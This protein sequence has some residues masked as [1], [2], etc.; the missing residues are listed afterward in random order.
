MKIAIISSTFL[1]AHEGVSITLWERLKKL[2]QLGHSALC[3]VSSY[4]ELKDVY[5]NW[6]DYVGCI[7]NNVEIVSLTS[8][9]WMGVKRE[10]NP[11]RNSVAII[12]KALERFQPDIIQIE[13]PDRLWT[14]MFTLPG[15]SYA[16]RSNIPCIASYRTNFIDYIPDY[17][18]GWSVN[19]SKLTVLL[20]TRWIYNQYSRTLVGSKF[21]AQRLQSWGISN[22]DYAQVIGSQLLPNPE[23]LRQPNFFQDV[24]G[25]QDVDCTVKIL[26]LGRLSPDK[27]W[28]FNCKYLPI[29]KRQRNIQ[30]FTIM[31]AGKGELEDDLLKGSFAQEL[32]PV[33]LGEVPCDRV[34]QLLANVDL[35]VTS[36]VK[37]TF[38]RT[39][40]ESLSVG[41]PVLAPDCPWTR[42]L[43]TP[44][45]DGVL[46]E[47]QNGKDFIQKLTELIN[48][49]DTR[50]LLRT[51]AILSSQHQSIESD[52]ASEWIKYLHNQLQTRKYC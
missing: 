7:L 45:F 1:P 12:N 33:M 46:Y 36:S 40:Q 26:F 50:A 51:N 8:Q 34:L 31:V 42:N 48:Q 27:N 19:I 20:L 39:V 13:E 37:E 21:M 43:V 3:L 4:E 25:L 24:Y 17:A 44:N 52:P 49:P 38:G 32:S 9:Q 2:S 22:V 14:T 11:I 28:E 16:K 6:S 15:L 5:P 35:H 23:K 30:K 10:R 29:L 18:P 41:T 47:A